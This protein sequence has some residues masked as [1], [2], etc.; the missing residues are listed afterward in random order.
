MNFG[1]LV[2]TTVNLTAL[3]LLRLFY[4]KNISNKWILDNAICQYM[5]DLHNSVK[6]DFLWEIE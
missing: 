4:R 3:Q 2:S 1:K 5:E 6:Q